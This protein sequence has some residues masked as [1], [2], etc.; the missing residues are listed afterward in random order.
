MAFRYNSK[1]EFHCRCKCIK[2]CF[3]LIQTTMARGKM[4]I[5]KELSAVLK[6]ICHALYTCDDLVKKSPISFPLSVQLMQ[7][8]HGKRNY[9]FEPHAAIM[10]WLMISIESHNAAIT[11]AI[12]CYIF[13]TMHGAFIF[14]ISKCSEFSQIACRTMVC[15]VSSLTADTDLI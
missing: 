2:A 3:S 15:L 11:E 12:R 1:I 7:M 14:E 8:D 9:V 4:F 5:G 10:K 13:D 6:H